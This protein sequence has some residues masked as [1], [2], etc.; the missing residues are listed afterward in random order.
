[1]YR[2]DGMDSVDRLDCADSEDSSN[3]SALFTQSTAYTCPL[4]FG[5]DDLFEESVVGI[6]SY[7]SW[8]GR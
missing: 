3:L 6:D 1:M 7:G 2:V 4:R 8:L 5:A